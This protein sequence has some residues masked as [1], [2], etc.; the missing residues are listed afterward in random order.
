M[1][2]RSS[3][4]KAFGPGVLFAG[5]AIGVSHLVQS[6]RAGADYGYSL[7]WAIILANVLKY[8]FFEFGTRYA[9][10]TQTSLLAGYHKL[11]K[12]PIWLYV[13]VTVSSMF[14]VTAAVTYVTV[15]LIASISGFTSSAALLIQVVVLYILIVGG[16]V[17]GQF[18]RLDQAIKI[19]AGTFVIALVV[20]VVA[21]AFNQPPHK[22]QPQLTTVF[23]DHSKLIFVI[24]LMGWMPTAID[25]SA[26]NS[27]WTIERT[28]SEKELPT[29]KQVLLDFKIGYWISATLALI[30]LVL[31]AELMFFQGTTFPK[32]PAAFSA[33]LIELFSAQVGAWS[34][35]FVA[36]AAIGVMLST[37]ITVFDGYARV[38]SI[39]SGMLGRSSHLRSYATWLFITAGGGLIVIFFF[40]QQLTKLVDVAT[41]ISFIVAPVVAILNL[42]LVMAKHFP[43]PAKP[44]KFMQVWA[45][46]GI[47][48]LFLFAALYLFSVI[49]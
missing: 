7:V 31:G 6:T 17:V 46:L 15:A 22:I 24:A 45:F 39:T 18:K 26:W 49:S 25:L 42:K 4:W 38:M 5:T 44:S 37:S 23:H 21:L 36:I 32:A 13:V 10:A 33:T 35:T 40:N 48:F 28:K 30:F 29:L 9:H 2:K 11:G 8:P 19:I 14:T 1:L 34:Y 3:F 41:T 20:A 43:N 47:I 27:I 12:L 16:L